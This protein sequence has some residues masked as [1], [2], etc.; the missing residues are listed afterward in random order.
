MTQGCFQVGVVAARRRLKGPWAEFAWM[1]FSILPSVPEAEPG[2]S[3]GRDGENELIYLGAT[4]VVLY[5]GS[6]AHYRD[7]LTAA[8]P[9][10][11]VVLRPRDEA[12]ELVSVL[13]DPY[14]AEALVGAGEDII[15]PVP[16]PPEIMAATVEFFDRFHVE[17]TF[18][19]R[20][21][22]RANPDALGR[23]GLAA[24][25]ERAASSEDR[26]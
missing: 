25:G 19:K 16:M 13:A 24:S 2:A 3:L 20:K 11:W 26:E 4:E 21:R 12:V 5:P 1:P 9:S 14:E 10:L 6:T 17:R 22:D 7:N 18:E 8:Q 15:E 23:R